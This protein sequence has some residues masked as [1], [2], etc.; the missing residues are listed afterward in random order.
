MRTHS[1]VGQDRWRGQWARLVNE[2]NATLN[3]ADTTQ[4]SEMCE[5]HLRN[6]SAKGLHHI[7]AAAHIHILGA[8]AVEKTRSKKLLVTSA[9]LVVTGAFNR[10]APLMT[11]RR[12]DGMCFE[13]RRGSSVER[14]RNGQ[15]VSSALL[16]V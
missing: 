16:L 4:T 3:S 2:I 13:M 11:T 6:E 5:I 15:R 10:K 14:E 8:Q 1:R 7:T 12:L 9:L